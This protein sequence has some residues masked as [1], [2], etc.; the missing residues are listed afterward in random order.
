MPPTSR[1]W[2][3]YEPDQPDEPAPP[4]R[5]RSCM[6]DVTCPLCA[7]DTLELVAEGRSDGLQTA[8]VVRCPPCNSKYLLVA[9]LEPYRTANKGPGTGA[10]R[11]PA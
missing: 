3:L 10:V 1:G 11:Q 6:V 8:I 4:R 9:R 2:S 7:L 5:V